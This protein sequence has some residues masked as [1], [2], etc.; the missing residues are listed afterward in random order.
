MFTEPCGDP[1]QKG[2]EDPR[3]IDTHGQKQ[4]TKVRGSAKTYQVLLVN[5]THGME[6]DK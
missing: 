2:R 5:Y 4:T 1:L 6:I 3:F